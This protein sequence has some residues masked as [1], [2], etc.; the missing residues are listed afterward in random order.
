[1]KKSKL[2]KQELFDF[3]IHLFQKVTVVPGFTLS[4]EIVEEA[5][6]WCGTIDPKDV[7]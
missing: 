3:S 6:N 7:L 4:S 2:S 1:L 5:Y